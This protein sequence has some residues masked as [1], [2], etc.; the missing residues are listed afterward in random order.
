[1]ISLDS[2]SMMAKFV[3]VASRAAGIAFALAP[4]G[5]IDRLRVESGLNPA[6]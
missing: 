5:C 4:K 1:M 3:R 6:F 2:T